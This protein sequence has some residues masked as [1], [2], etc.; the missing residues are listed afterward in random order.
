M[1]FGKNRCRE[2]DME[3]PIMKR[4]ML[5]VTLLLVAFFFTCRPAGAE[6]S[7]ENRVLSIHK[8]IEI[9]LEKNPEILSAKARLESSAHMVSAARSGLMPRLDVSETFQNTSV[10]MWVFGTKLNQGTI[11]AMDFNPSR[12]NDPDD[13]SNFNTKV[14]MTWPLYDGGKTFA[15]LARSKLAKEVS[16]L[17]LKKVQ[18]DIISR[19][20]QAYVGVLLASENLKVVNKAL[21]TAIAHMKTVKNRYHNGF[22]VKS[23]LLRAQVR[24]AELV[25]QQLDAESRLDIAIA[26]L[27]TVMGNPVDSR[28]VLSTPFQNC[29]ETKGDQDLWIKKALSNRPDLKQLE[30]RQQI[31]KKKIEMSRAGHLPQV[32]LNGD[33]EIN[34]KSFDGSADCYTVGATVQLNLFAGN[35]ISARVRAAKAEMES[36]KAMYEALKNAVKLQVRREYLS[37]QS[38][39][40]RIEVAGRSVAQSEENLRIVGNRYKNGLLTIVDL[41]DAQ[42]ADQKARSLHFQALHDYKVAR[43]KL[44]AAAGIIDADFR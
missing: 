40:Q 20:A 17:G 23:D 19:T 24:I 27:N 44:A 34:S 18:Q 7:G 12:L 30:I 21:E 36:V 2:N 10:P 28:P 37:A 9:A 38:A 22:V 5:V 3:L 42:V 13:I 29:V 11:T 32:F 4:R 39:W 16:L 41:L 8:A 33:Y 14:S 6:T 31:A 25:Q 43:I 1:F 26:M 35:G 15:D